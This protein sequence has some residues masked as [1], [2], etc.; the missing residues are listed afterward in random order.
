MGINDFIDV[1]LKPNYNCL[2]P[3]HDY[4]IS[5]KSDEVSSVQEGFLSD[6][7]AKPV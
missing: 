2:T 4:H 7:E 6:P 1:G 5:E 3:I